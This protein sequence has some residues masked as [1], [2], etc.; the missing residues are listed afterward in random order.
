MDA[1]FEVARAAIGL[2]PSDAWMLK[3]GAAIAMATVAFYNVVPR[4]F[5]DDEEGSADPAAVAQHHPRYAERHATLNDYKW[6]S[7][8]DYELRKLQETPQFQKWWGENKDRVEKDSVMRERQQHYLRCCLA[9]MAVAASWMLP[10][11]NSDSGLTL[12]E[13]T[14]ARITAS[15]AASEWS[16]FGFNFAAIGV[17]LSVF[18]L[19]CS[20]LFSCKVSDT[21]SVAAFVASF[22]LLQSV[23]LGY[24]FVVLLSIVAAKIFLLPF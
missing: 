6:S 12:F 17:F 4:L 11:G 19:H 1:F 20:L 2:N 16:V 5:A 10:A 14:T 8:T 3:S 24:G 21:I 18:M 23:A 7:T 9:L 22:Y 13:M 15:P